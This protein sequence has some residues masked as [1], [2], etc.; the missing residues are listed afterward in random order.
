MVIALSISIWK[1]EVAWKIGGKLTF[2]LRYYGTKPF[3][4]HLCFASLLN[5]DSRII[6]LRI[7]IWFAI[8][9]I[10]LILH[11]SADLPPPWQPMALLLT[12]L[13]QIWTNLGMKPM[14]NFAVSQYFGYLFQEEYVNTLYWNFLT[15]I[16]LMISF[17]VVFADNFFLGF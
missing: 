7:S 2:Y 1:S 15:K 12:M 11:T 9:R 14:T 6:T 3:H 10:A 8:Y 17:C 13:Y 4:L 16:V 5:Y